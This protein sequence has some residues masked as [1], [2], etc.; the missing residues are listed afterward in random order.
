LR[1]ENAD[2]ADAIIEVHEGQGQSDQEQMEE[3]SEYQPH[4]DD[5]INGSDD[6][7]EVVRMWTPPANP[8]PS[9][10]EKKHAERK[11]KLVWEQ[12]ITAK[13]EGK[14]IS[15][16]CRHCSQQV[17]AQPIRMEKH[18]SG[19]KKFKKNAQDP[20]DSITLSGNDRI[21]NS[22][23]PVSADAVP[24][25]SE[26]TKQPKIQSKLTSFLNK[27]CPKEK[28][29]IDEKVAEFIYSNNL[30]FTLVDSPEFK[31]LMLLVS[32]GCY[33]PPSS[34]SIG[35]N[36]L[37]ESFKKTKEEIL[38]E[39]KGRSVTIAQDGWTTNQTSPILAHCMVSNGK[40]YFLNAV[41]TG[42]EKKS[43]EFCYKVLNDAIAIA[44]NKFQVKTVGVVTDNCNTMIAMH[45]IIRER[46]SKL[47]SK[48]WQILGRAKKFHEG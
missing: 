34:K 36:L 21:P 23:M 40:P 19:C 45:D 7:N 32:K 30:P 33:A 15:N 39:V 41:S 26:G 8:G 31:D 10:N 37:E 5:D 38:N 12:F 14:I 18:L 44:E 43:S 25:A 35:E 22:E 46:D 24:D 20:E 47:Y 28:V 2:V 3:D 1:Q 48:P 4:I 6:Q 16:K 13:N 29:K 11:Q 42:I 17:S 9:T 27:I